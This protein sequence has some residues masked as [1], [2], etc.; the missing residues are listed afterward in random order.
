MRLVVDDVVSREM[1]TSEAG[2][3]REGWEGMEG[4]VFLGGVGVGANFGHRN[5]CAGK[6]VVVRVILDCVD[7]EVVG[8]GCNVCTVVGDVVLLAREEGGGMFLQ[9]ELCICVSVVLELVWGV[10]DWFFWVCV[11][12][13]LGCWVGG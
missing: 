10:K 11:W 3:V 4:V 8:L 9:V 5:G 1:V 7:L 6:G 2:G 13:E 12:G